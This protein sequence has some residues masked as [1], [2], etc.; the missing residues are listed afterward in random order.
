MTVGLNRSFAELSDYQ[1][2]QY[3]LLP[4][5]FLSLDTNRY[6]VSNIAGNYQVMQRQDLD[7]LVRHR[8]PVH[9]PVYDDLKANHFLA[10]R[11]SNVYRD[12]LAAKYRT[13]QARLPDFTSLHLFVVTLRCDHSCQY[14]QVSRVSEDRAAFD[15]TRETAD[16]AIALMLE[17]PS[18][19]LKVEFQ[20]GEPLLNFDLIRHIVLEVERLAGGRKV[21]F[22]ITSNLSPLTDEILEFAAA[23]KIFFSTSLDGPAD[24]HNRNRPR[25][26]G[27]SHARAVAG[28]ERIRCRL[29]HDAVAALMTST[30]ESLKQPV[31]IIDEYVR[32]GF[33][34]IFLRFISPYG[35]AAKTAKRIGYETDEFIEFFKRGLAYIVSLNQR[36]I[37]FRETYSTLLLQRM[38]TSYATG[39]VDLQS[40]AGIGISVLAYNYDGGVYAADEGRMLAEMGDETF[41]LGSVQD[42]Y[43]ELF[44][45][46][47]LFSTISDTMLEGLPGCCDCALLP[48]CGSDPVFHHRTQGDVIGHRPTSAFCRRN[49]EIMRHL[50]RLLED[51]PETAAVLRAWI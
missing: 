32:L 11:D 45:N 37:R 12:L 43:E 42:S 20:G 30:A 8:L 22:V 4:I 21:Q 40:P 1:S 19:Q 14:C 10:D 27:D 15:M 39:Y 48:Y 35:F 41:R 46:S 17:S 29:G 7:D 24:L 47:P 25:P 36:G 44:A 18:R 9:S 5:R 50:I 23:H 16:R 3:C 6:I 51:E 38:L 28:I 33:D 31:A 26:G 49:M 2:D 13:R 34:S